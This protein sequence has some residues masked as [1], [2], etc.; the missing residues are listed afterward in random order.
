MRVRKRF[1]GWTLLCGN[2]PETFA[3]LRQGYGR[4]M[5]GIL[6]LHLKFASK[7]R[8]YPDSSQPEGASLQSC[9]PASSA[10]GTARTGAHRLELLPFLAPLNFQCITG[11]VPGAWH[12]AA[13]KLP[14]FP[15]C[16]H[17]EGAC[18]ETSCSVSSAYGS[19]GTGAE[20]VVIYAS[21]FSKAMCTP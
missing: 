20:R 11:D 17:P 8:T 6:G 1:P 19:A 5:Q 7:K 18:L 12:S 2:Y 15:H 13:P 9:C 3:L 14:T 21:L 4:L 10:R 16:S